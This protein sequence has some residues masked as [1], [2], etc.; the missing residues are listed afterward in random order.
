MRLLPLLLSA[1]ALAGCTF[2]VKESNIVF[3]RAVPVPDIALVR[4]ANPGYRVEQERIR[5]GDGEELFSLRFMREDA[6]ATVLYFGGNGYSIARMGGQ[7][8][9]VYGKLPVNLVLVDHRG[10][11]GSTGSAS[12]P[13]LMSDAVEAYDAVR[14]DATLGGLPVVVHGHSLGSFMAGALADGRTLDGLVLESTVTTAE[15]WTAFLRSQQRWWI[16]AVVW[17]VR[18]GETL[19]GLGNAGPV[20]RL[21]EPVLFVVGE[22]DDVTPPEFS[23]ELFEAAPGPEEDRRL[24]VVAGRDHMNAADSPEFRAAM[25]AML[26]R[27]PSR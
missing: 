6:V 11:G 3:G 17:R 10:Y 8:A 13:A 20:S 9:S 25:A 7:T 2:N 26:E 23:R 27:L 19:R 22:D 1:L 21:D 5:T 18:P 24:V 16:R 15:A 12:L 14:A 4:E